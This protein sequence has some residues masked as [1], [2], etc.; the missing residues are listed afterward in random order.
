MTSE[1][2]ALRRRTTAADALAAVRAWQP[3]SDTLS[4]LFVIDQDGRLCGVVSLRQ[5]MIADR[6]GP[7]ANLYGSRTDL[8]GRRQRPGNSAPA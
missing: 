4:D 8:G 5:L 7:G 6:R 3:K 1:F 2:L